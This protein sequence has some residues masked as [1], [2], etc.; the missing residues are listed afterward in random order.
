MPLLRAGDNP[1]TSVAILPVEELC[2]WQAMRLMLAKGNLD[3][4]GLKTRSELFFWC[5]VVS[6]CHWPYPV[7]S[8][9]A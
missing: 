5:I 3:H 9:V 7:P 4:G 6:C 2:S 8:M 1:W